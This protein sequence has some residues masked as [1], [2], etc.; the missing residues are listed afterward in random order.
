MRFT[1]PLLHTLS[2]TPGI[3]IVRLVIIPVTEFERAL[4]E[5]TTEVMDSETT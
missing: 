2:L 3:H 5:T 4:A 1:I